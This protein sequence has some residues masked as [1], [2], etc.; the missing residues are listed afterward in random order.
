MYLKGVGK[1]RACH[2]G[3]TCCFRTTSFSQYAV[4]HRFPSLSA[5]MTMIHWLCSKTILWVKVAT[6]NTVITRFYGSHSSVGD[7]QLNLPATST[8]AHPSAQHYYFHILT[9]PTVHHYTIYPYFLAQPLFLDW[10]ALTTKA[11]H[12]FTTTVCLTSNNSEDIRLQHWCKT[13]NHACLQALKGGGILIC[14]LPTSM[15]KVNF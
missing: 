5:C 14:L 10:L 4:T 1:W 11:L 15:Q 6:H 9:I 12:S 3:S 8:R 13:L 2:G 7:R